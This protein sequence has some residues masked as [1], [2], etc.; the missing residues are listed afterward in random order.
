[1][2][3]RVLTRRGVVLIVEDDANATSV[4]REY[5]SRA[6]FDVR[7]A[8]NGWDALKRLRDGDID[9]VVSETRVSDM[10]GASL[11]E[12]CIMS[13]DSRDLPFLFLVSPKDT[14]A[15]VRAL[16]SGVDDCIPKPI[17]P[18]VLVARVQA[19]LERRR[20]YAEMV[21]IDPLTRMLNRPTLLREIDVE[22]HRAQRYGRPA[23]LAL[24]DIDRFHA[25]NEEAG[26]AMGD[27]LLACL[28]GVILT[29]IRNVDLAGRYRGESFLLFL[30]ETGLDGARI[31]VTRMQ[32]RL[33]HIADGVAAMP[34]SVTCALAH[35]PEHGTALDNLLPVLEACLERTKSTERGGCGVAE[36]PDPL[37]A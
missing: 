24:I 21:R 34:L 16:R 18:V 15:Q 28:S 1:M 33:R 31:L 13:P 7:V 26:V 14:E 5:L 29:N 6:H 37:P 27:L 30:P 32:E 22:L 4:M 17:D 10:D 11:R 12:K 3:E 2:S 19:V 25:V 9:V 35:T 8:S 36:V 23:S 20:S